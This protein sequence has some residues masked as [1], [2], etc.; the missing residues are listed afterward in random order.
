MWQLK[1][2]LQYEVAVWQAFDKSIFVTKNDYESAIK[3]T[4]KVVNYKIIEDRYGFITDGIHIKDNLYLKYKEKENALAFAASDQIQNIESIK[5]FIEKVWKPMQKKV[6]LRLQIYGKI[7]EP[8]KKFFHKNLNSLNVY[9]MG[10]IPD[11]EE[12]HNL[13]AK[14]K[15]F[16]SPTFVG[17]GYR[18]KIFEAGS[19]GMPI[20]CS[21][22]D[23]NSL[24]DDFKPNNNILV[25]NDL[26]EF[27]KLILKIDKNEIDL[28]TISKNIHNTSKNYSW[29]NVAEKFINIYEKTSKK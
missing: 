11:I 8:L 3:Y 10:F 24:P 29:D 19:F 2:T 14:N 28:F 16:L 20:M 25:A 7:C 5:L 1:K 12:L 18:T 27:K 4:Q 15:A 26:E 22:F 21:L 17:S 6:N 13:I 23:Y 9:L